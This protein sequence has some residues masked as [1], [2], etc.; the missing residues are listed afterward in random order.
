MTTPMAK[1]TGRS[2]GPSMPANTTATS[3]SGKPHVRSVTAVM[4]VSNLPPKYPAIDPMTK[5]STRVKVVVITATSREIPVPATV[6]QRMS[7]PYSS[8]PSMCPWTPGASSAS[9]RF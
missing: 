2:P 4:T 5:P 1:I 7:R 8:V 9:E 6:R 3:S